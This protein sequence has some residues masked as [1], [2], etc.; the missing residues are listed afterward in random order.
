MAAVKLVNLAARRRALG[1][2]DIPDTAHETVQRVVMDPL[3]ARGVIYCE[4]QWWEYGP[5]GAWVPMPVVRIWRAVQELNGTET[6]EGAGGKNPGK[7]IRVTSAMCESVEALG[8]ARFQQDEWGDCTPGFISPR[9]LWTC[10]QADGWTCRAPTPEDRVRMF[11]DVDPDTET[12]PP[13]WASALHRL[14]GHEDDYQARFSFLH[15]WI[16]S[17]LLGLA[18]R[19]QVAPILHGDGENGKSV[20]VDVI[21]GAIPLILRCAVTPEDLENSP[22][23]SA[24]LVGKALNAVAELPGGE[25][26]TSHR[27]K[28]IIDGSEQT[29]E[30][31]HKDGFLFRPFSAHIFSAND[32][33]HVRDLSHG[34]WRRW[35]VLTCTAPKLTAA[36]RRMDFARE[37][38]ADE[39]PQ[40][41][42]YAMR[43]YEAMVREGRGFTV[44][45]SSAAAISEWRGGSDSVQAWAEEATEP[46]GPSA[47]RGLYDS[48]RR[49]AELNGSR[50]VG[51]KTFSQRLTK[52]GF[53]E[54]RLAAVR[55]RGLVV[56]VF[57]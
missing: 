49:H 51:S 26:L 15:E 35:V 22:F 14:W 18:T 39:I 37:I 29:A 28:A 10:T 50:P 16:A 31:K 42:G 33:P 46:G 41:L 3:A 57:T 55:M 54:V 34:F 38:L 24:R 30:R 53:P 8:R 4:G 23:A 27:I 44:V 45:P 48:Y 40:I 2:P 17:M 25:L 7:C 11:V 36:E 52:L 47:T 9:G 21:S 32:L 12:D 6:L 20:V 5:M 19:H 43:C 1:I 13:K 56:K